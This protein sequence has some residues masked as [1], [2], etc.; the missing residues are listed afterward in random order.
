MNYAKNPVLA[1]GPVEIFRS[2]KAV[3]AIIWLYRFTR[4]HFPPD[5]VATRVAAFIE[6]RL[7][8][9]RP[10]AIHVILSFLSRTRSGE[11]YSVGM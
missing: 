3:L 8:V 4:P 7:P 1:S 6:F 9:L 11:N 2:N 10:L 5:I